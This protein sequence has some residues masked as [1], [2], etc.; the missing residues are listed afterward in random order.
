L[1]LTIRI[2]YRNWR[3]AVVMR[4]SHVRRRVRTPLFPCA[5]VPELSLALLSL[6][7]ASNS[8][9][10]TQQNELHVLLPIMKMM[11]ENFLFSLAEKR[12]KK[13]KENESLY[14]T[15]TEALKNEVGNVNHFYNENF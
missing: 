12:E 11:M 7:R 15:V 10:E 14:N 3:L 13:T 5:V 9:S 4:N 8:V 1:S 2:R 6:R